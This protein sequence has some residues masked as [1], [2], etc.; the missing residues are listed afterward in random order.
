[1]Q[2]MVNNWRNIIQ[3]FLFPPTCILCNAPGISNMDICQHC[4]DDMPTNRD[5][6][7]RCAEPFASVNPSAQLCGRCLSRPPAYTETVAPFLYQHGMRYLITGLKFGKQH[8]NARLLAELMSQHLHSNVQMP[9]CII[10]VPLHPTRYRERGFNQSIEIA[11]TLTRRLSVPIDINAVIRTRNT[12]HQTD[13]AAKQ[14]RSNM[15]RAFAV[16][17]NLSWNHVAIVDDVMTTGSTV[18]ELAATLKRAGVER[19]DVWVCARA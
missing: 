11:K 14:R 7:Y 12:V 9:D 18:L 19:V 8:K 5:C 16:T 3:Q 6:C 2:I 13:L 10:P 1:M 15:K 17:R 4:L